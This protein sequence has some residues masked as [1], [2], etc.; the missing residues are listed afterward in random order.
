MRMMSEVSSRSSR[1]FAARESVL[2]H[3]TADIHGGERLR[4]KRKGNRATTPSAGNGCMASVIGTPQAQATKRPVIGV[5][6]HDN[7]MRGLLTEWLSAAG[8]AVRDGSVG[9]RAAHHGVDLIIVDVYMPRQS[10]ARIIRAVQRVYPGT[11]IIAISGQFRPGLANS[12][13]A[14][15]DLG[16]WRLL[17]KP[18]SREDLLG[19]VRAVIAA[20]G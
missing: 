4:L 18:F 1:A 7:L 16:A 8:Y 15:R 5:I 19:A 17:P 13:S 14:A 20:S 6:E 2:L 3:C 11:P 12:C 10:G 9:Q